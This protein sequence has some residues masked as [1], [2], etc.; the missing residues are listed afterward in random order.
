[1]PI[2]AGV[3]VVKHG[4]TSMQ[5]HTWARDLM[6]EVSFCAASLGHSCDVNAAEERRSITCVKAVHRYS[7]SAYAGSCLSM[8]LKSAWL[9]VCSQV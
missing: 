5:L 8:P 3:H 6:Q 4:S 7:C 2:L 1:M 9:A